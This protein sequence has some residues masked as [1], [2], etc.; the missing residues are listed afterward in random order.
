MIRDFEKTQDE[1][2]LRT[3]WSETKCAA[4]Q[5]KEAL[6]LVLNLNLLLNQPTEAVI[7]SNL[8]N[9]QLVSEG[10]IARS[11]VVLVLVKFQ[12]WMDVVPKEMKALVE[13]VDLDWAMDFT[14]FPEVDA[15]MKMPFKLVEVPA[16]TFLGLLDLLLAQPLPNLVLEL[17]KEV[18]VPE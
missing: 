6:H 13:W 2:Q 1:L 11:K 9:T 16:S 15:F 3:D 8:Y 4:A 5:E 17:V 18:L 7:K 10:H 14:Y 12:A